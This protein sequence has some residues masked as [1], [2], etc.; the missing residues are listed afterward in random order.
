MYAREAAIRQYPV[1]PFTVYYEVHETARIVRILS[2]VH[3]SRNVVEL[4][5]DADG[6]D[7]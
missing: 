7:G 6:E 5:S 3:A 1:F 2:V 4:G